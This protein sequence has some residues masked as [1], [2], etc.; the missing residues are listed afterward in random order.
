MGYYNG[1]TE[2]AV[3]MERRV[4]PAHREVT[5]KI[6]PAGRYYRRFEGSWQIRMIPMESSPHSFMDP[7]TDRS[8]DDYSPEAHHQICAPGGDVALRDSGIDRE[9]AEHETCRDEGLC[10][11]GTGVNEE[12]GGKRHSGQNGISEEAQLGASHA[13]PLNPCRE[14]E[15]KGKLCHAE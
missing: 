2:E 1:I 6:G 10:D 11:R 4:Y 14:I 8:G 13:Y 15:D 12:Y 3:Q 7:A 5:L 9:T